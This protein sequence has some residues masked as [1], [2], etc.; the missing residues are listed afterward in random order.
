MTLF[1]SLTFRQLIQALYWWFI[2][3]ACNKNAAWNHAAGYHSFFLHGQYQNLKNCSRHVKALPSQEMHAQPW[4]LALLGFF[5]SMES[6]VMLCRFLDWF[7]EYE[8]RISRKILC[9]FRGSLKIRPPS[10][11]ESEPVEKSTQKSDRDEH[12]SFITNNDLIEKCNLIHS[13]ITSNT[14]CLSW[15]GSPKL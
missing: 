2:L 9:G 15:T 14:F 6:L 4:Q 1:L 8:K 5:C 11:F 3:A 7:Y 12:I 10:P 13:Q